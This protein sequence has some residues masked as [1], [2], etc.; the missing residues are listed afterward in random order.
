M[1]REGI[2]FLLVG[3]SGAGKNTLMKRV[4][5]QLGDLPQ[6]ATATTRPMRAGEKEGREHQ[7]VTLKE[8]NRL[9]DTGALVEYQAVHAGKM[10]GT[11]RKTVEEAIA[12]GRSLIADI[13]PLGA[14]KVHEAYPNNT[15]LI[16]VTPSHL[17]TLKA[18]IRQR[19]HVKPDVLAHRLARVPFEM[20]FAGECHYIL[21]NDWIDPAS[22]HLYQVIL[23][24]R[25]KRWGTPIPMQCILEQ[26]QIHSTMIA[27]IQHG[28][29]LLL[30]LENE[31]PVFPTHTIV[32]PTQPPHETVQAFVHTLTPHT[33]LDEI[34]D[35]RFDFPAPHDAAVAT[36]PHDAYL[37]FYYKFTVPQRTPI[38]GWE[39]HAISDLKLPPAIAKLVQ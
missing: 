6:L 37:Y 13:E 25:A 10:Y 29:H 3:P 7:F 28:D 20:A 35:D 32:D 14:L 9:I 38:N 15:V 4:Q 33:I 30:R 11:P 19:G 23:S 2:L 22:D 36:I 27:L 17:N 18:R 39:W 1:S 24:E 21:L 16:F 12:T 5:Q 8:F 31:H 26:P 34:R